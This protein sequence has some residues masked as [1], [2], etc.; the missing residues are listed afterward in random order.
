MKRKE[1]GA[2]S[3]AKRMGKESNLFDF[4]LAVMGRLDVR[5]GSMKKKRGREG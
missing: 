5:Q 3:R 4:R 1:R 2:K